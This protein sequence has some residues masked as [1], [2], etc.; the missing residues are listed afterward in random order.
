MK[1][2]AQPDDELFLFQSH[3]D[4]LLNP[5]HPLIK[6]SK[7]VD[8]DHFDQSFGEFFCESVGAPAKA[9]RLMVGLIYLKHAFNE[10]DESV[11]E[12]LG[13]EPVLAVF[14]R[15][16]ALAARVSD[17]SHDDDQMAKSCG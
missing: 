10:S 9:T 17:S 6:L 7:Q 14:L 2:Q 12:R 8:W 13:G 15:I 1:P 5:T 16:H 11:V 4:Q 3:F